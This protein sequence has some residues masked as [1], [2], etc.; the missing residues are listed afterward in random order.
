MRKT[1]LV[2]LML[3]GLL[4][5]TGP[6]ALAQSYYSLQG[7]G[8]FAARQD[9]QGAR[10][11]G[12]G[13]TRADPN[14][15]D[16]WYA[17]AVARENPGQLPGAIEAG[18]RA[19]QL[20]RRRGATLDQ[21]FARRVDIRGLRSITG[22]RDLLGCQRTFMKYLTFI[23]HAESYREAGPPR[24]LM[25]AMGQFVQ[26]ALQ[27]GSLVDTGGLLPSKDGFRIRLAKGAIS[28]TDG[29][30]IET[31]EVI[32]GW[33]IIEADSKS[34]ALRIAQEFMELHRKHWP[35]FEGEAEV[36]P[37]FEPGEGP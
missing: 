25:E 36:R 30:F 8:Q 33:A 5:G 1:T 29:P 2:T 28:M 27:D 18:R 17:V 35:Q 19:V 26:K 13:W 16:A 21:F 9:W 4:L 10:S 3:A 14:S 24:A 6:V 34:E 12:L 22:Q 11:Y 7:I 23:R 37:M 32:G 31:K 15:A 20:N